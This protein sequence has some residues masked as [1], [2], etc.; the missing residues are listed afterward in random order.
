MLK[1]HGFEYS[2]H[3]GFAGTNPELDKEMM[4]DIFTTP[5]FQPDY[6]KIYPCRDVRVY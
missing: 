1:E 2:Y 5:H 6:L 4:P 3:A